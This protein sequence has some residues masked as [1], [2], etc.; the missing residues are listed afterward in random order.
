M[1]NESVRAFVRRHPVVRYAARQLRV[2][3]PESWGGLDRERIPPR[4]REFE[5]A[6]P[7]RPDAETPERS[8]LRIRAPGDYWVPSRLQAEGL[9]GYERSGIACFLAAI[10]LSPPG[11]VLDVGANI[12]LYAALASARSQRPV[13]AFEPTPAV[14]QVAR[15][16]AV[17]NDL[18][19]T[20]VELALSNHTGTGTL[21]L[22]GVTEGS[23][24]LVEGPYPEIGRLQV[25]VDTLARWRDRAT[26][27]PSVIKIDTESTEPDVV[28]G[29]L[30]IL[31]RF[32]PWVV[33][34][35]RPERDVADRLMALLEPLEYTWHCLGRRTPAPAQPVIVGDTER[36]VWLFAPVEPTDAFWSRVEEWRAALGL[37]QPLAPT[38]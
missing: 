35:V 24:S 6:L 4:V 22:S 19:Y 25:P 26:I 28:A 20:V 18:N 27:A 29:A 15:D 7:H 21:R 9:V 11:A 3:L 38:G 13:F 5:L 36:P 31:R 32:R 17:D 33:C 8:T 12:G 16:I 1:V 2:R 37:C 23:N 14:A 10:E 30:E 34:E